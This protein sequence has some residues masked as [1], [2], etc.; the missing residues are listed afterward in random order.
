MVTI[1]CI[2]FLLGIHHQRTMLTNLTCWCKS[3]ATRRSRPLGQQATRVSIPA[4]VCVCVSHLPYAAGV[5]C[6]LADRSM[7][8]GGKEMCGKVSWFLLFLFSPRLPVS[9]CSAVSQARQVVLLTA[10]YQ[11]CRPHRGRNECV[12]SDETGHPNYRDETRRG[13]L[14]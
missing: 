13:W 4:C 5:A 12:L 3:R 11:G 10:V 9:P 7:Q 2:E 8:K 6:E 1:R 14:R